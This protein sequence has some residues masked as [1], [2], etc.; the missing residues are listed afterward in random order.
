MVRAEVADP[1]PPLT[2]SLTV[3][4]P[5]FFDDSPLIHFGQICRSL[6]YGLKG[7]VFV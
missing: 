6:R 5:F 4:Y 2:V 3:K 1:T 7:F